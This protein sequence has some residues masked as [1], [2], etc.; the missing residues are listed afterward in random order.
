M[1]SDVRPLVDVELVKAPQSG[2]CEIEIRGIE[3]YCLCDITRFVMI[4]VTTIL[5]INYNFANYT[6]I[7]ITN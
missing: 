6:L 1:V 4:F 7:T 5:P 2:N 3:R